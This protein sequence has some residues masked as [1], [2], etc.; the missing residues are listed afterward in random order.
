V[1]SS[2][3]LVALLAL[4]AAACGGGL[5]PGSTV[6]PAALCDGSA[7]PRLAYVVSGGGQPYPGVPFTNAYGYEF[8]V[9][10]GGCHYW[11]GGDYAKGIRT[12]TLTAAAAADISRRLHLG[13]LARLKGCS[14]RPVFD[15]PAVLLG[16][17]VDTVS[18]GCEAPGA[19][20]GYAETWANLPGVFQQLLAGGPAE[21]PVRV[22]AIAD[23][24]PR[25]PQPAQPWTLS[26]SPQ[27]IVAELSALEPG[28][29]RLVSAPGELPALR[30]LRAHVPK[31]TYPNGVRVRDATGASFLVFP[32]DEAPVA[33]V[34]GLSFLLH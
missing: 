3:R 16:D 19:P 26:W 4:G 12:G 29:G 13:E 17:G 18:A 28:S 2:P 27:E 32:R 20:A 11:A 30:M 8:F 6:V 33:V 31:D 34:E 10:D 5:D 1:R 15:A 7:S 14:P 21:L 23:E 25:D 9:I 22:A 24:F